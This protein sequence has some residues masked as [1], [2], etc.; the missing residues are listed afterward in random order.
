MW[1]KDNVRHDLEASVETKG[2]I[3]TDGRKY[4]L[5]LYRISPLDVTWLE[6]HW[7]ERTEDGKPQDPTKNYPHRMAVLRPE[8]V[9]SFRVSKL[10]EYVREEHAKKASLPHTNGE[11]K[12]ENDPSLAPTSNG[13]AQESG[14]VSKADEAH[15]SDEAPKYTQE[16]DRVDVSGFKFALNPDVFCGQTP[17]TEEERSELE[18]DEVMV[19]NACNHLTNVVIPELVNLAFPF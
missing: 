7:S 17:Q 8:L 10:R 13:D 3:G 16:P 19:R 12:A 1:D 9:E 11:N 18:A 4:V 14:T 5:D 6:Q 2:L 15:T